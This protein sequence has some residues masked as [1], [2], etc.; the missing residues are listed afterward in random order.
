M[1]KLFKSILLTASLTS[2]SMVAN[3]NL[4]L[5][6]SFEESTSLTLTPVG[7][8]NIGH[9]DG[10]ITYSSFNTPA[11]DGDN[12]YDLGGYGNAF[13]PIG[14]GVAQTFGTTIGV[15]YTVSFGLSGEN[16]S[17]DETLT[18]S[19]GN[20]S[21]DYVVTPNG[22]GDFQ[23]PFVTQ[24]FKFVAASTTTTLS[25]IHTFGEGGNNDPLIDGVSVT[26]AVPEPEAYA[27]LL[28]GLVVAG[29]S[30][31]RRRRS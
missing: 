7:W 3:A 9:S 31:A 22:L 21:L 12:Y 26:A 25:F 18:V 5:N 23:Q 2:V 17:G 6:G 28:A 13:G 19:A 30:V 20:V 27:L 8:F 16:R 24:T 14:D 15:T 4:L 10:V 29:G 11:Y 1:L